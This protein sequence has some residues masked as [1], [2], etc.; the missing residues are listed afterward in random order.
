MKKALK[1]MNINVI[2][3]L[4]RLEKLEEEKRRKEFERKRKAHYN[5]GVVLKEWK[6]IGVDE[7]E[8]ENPSGK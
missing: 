7:I 6:K 8:D 1:S 4:N 2:I 5:E 3:S